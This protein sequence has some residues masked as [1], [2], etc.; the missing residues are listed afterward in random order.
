VKRNTTLLDGNPPVLSGRGD[1]AELQ[2]KLLQAVPATINFN[3]SVVFIGPDNNDIT[4]HEKINGLVVV[5]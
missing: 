1:L 3:G 2:E 4:I 5:E